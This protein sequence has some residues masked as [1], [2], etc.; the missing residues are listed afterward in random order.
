MK[1]P[2][3]ATSGRLGR[4]WL[5]LCG[6]LLAALPARAAAPGLLLHDD[7]GGKAVTQY[8]HDVWT[9]DDGLPQNTVNAIVQTRDGYLWAG[10]Q[11]G[12]V[13]FDG[14][15]FT[16]FDRQ[17]APGLRSNYV[18]TLYEDDAGR[19]WAG[20]NGGGLSRFDGEGFTTFTTA[21]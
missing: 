19:L 4:A 16:V 12:I 20:T 6:L 8:V 13:R 14:V 1:N 5:P 2:S 15:S 21:D 9:T 7:P 11:E 10:T 3:R 17:R 18:W